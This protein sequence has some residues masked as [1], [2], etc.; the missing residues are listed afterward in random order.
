M[1]EYLFFTQR[2]LL[3]II[4]IYP[5]SDSPI[6]LIPKIYSFLVLC[7]FIFFI[8]SPFGLSSSEG[9]A[10][11]SFYLSA[12]LFWGGVEGE[13]SVSLEAGKYII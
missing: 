6:H 9:E 5:I 3:F 4:Q 12:V 7:P 8:T 2:I 10:L 11:F 1:T 13:G